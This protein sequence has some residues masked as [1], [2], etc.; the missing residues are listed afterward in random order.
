MPEDMTNYLSGE[1][2]T[3]ESITSPTHDAVNG[4][5]VLFIGWTPE[6]VG[7]ILGWEDEDP[8]VLAEVTFAGK[9]ITPVLSLIH[10]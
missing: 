4:K 6:P 1:K 9:D 5:S 3:L 7:K 2:L 10:I 8:V